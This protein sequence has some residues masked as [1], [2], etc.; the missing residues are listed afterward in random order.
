ML[1]APLGLHDAS[2]TEV[3][4]ISLFV[5]LELEGKPEGIATFCS[6]ARQADEELAKW[7]G[8]GMGNARAVSHFKWP[9]QPPC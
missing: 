9:C 5:L 1:W 6:D 4:L 2:E 7:T 8:S 3:L